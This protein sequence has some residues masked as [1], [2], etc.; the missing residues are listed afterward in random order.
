[1]NGFTLLESVFSL[2]ILMVI[3]AMM[4]LLLK[5][6]AGLDEDNSSFIFKANLFLEQSAVEIR[7][8]EFIHI[9]GSKLTMLNYDGEE[10]LYELNGETLR[11]RVNGLGHE[12]LLQNVE[13]VSYTHTSTTLTINVLDVMGEQVER[14]FLVYN[15]GV[16][17]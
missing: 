13:S 3:I 11:R 8:A 4:P 10:I 14:T 2:F 17:N 15:T 6:T 12:V 16:F 5:V 7:K 1:M 9:Q